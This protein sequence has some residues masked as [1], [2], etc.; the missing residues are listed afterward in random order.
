MIAPVKRLG[1]CRATMVMMGI[2]AL[3]KA[4]LAMTI[5]SFRPLDRAVRT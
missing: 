4:C 5:P 2:K 3:R 1:N